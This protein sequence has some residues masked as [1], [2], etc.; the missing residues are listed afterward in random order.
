MAVESEKGRL[1]GAHTE[2]GTRSSKLFGCD[3]HPHEIP[4]DSWASLVFP[5]SVRR[6]SISDNLQE[7]QPVH[8]ICSDEFIKKNR[9]ASHSF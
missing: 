1:R 9:R 8:C 4:L 6:M 2:K 3:C 5:M 7:S